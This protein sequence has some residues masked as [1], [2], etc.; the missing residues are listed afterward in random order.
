MKW[1]IS[2]QIPDSPP[3]QGASDPTSGLTGFY[4]YP[5]STLIYFLH[6]S[7]SFSQKKTTVMP[8]QVIGH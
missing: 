1:I 7:T 3:T 5:F 8:P 6:K 2:R 4:V